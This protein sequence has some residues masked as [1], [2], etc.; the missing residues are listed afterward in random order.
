MSTEHGCDEKEDGEC[1]QDEG[2][3]ENDGRHRGKAKG[4]GRSE[5][6]HQL[7]HRHANGSAGLGKPLLIQCQVSWGVATK[8]RFLDCQEL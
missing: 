6:S 4:F 8:D 3:H 5:R 1:E 2:H 7:V